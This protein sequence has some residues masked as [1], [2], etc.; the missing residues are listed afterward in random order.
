MYEPPNPEGGHFEGGG[1]EGGSLEK[2]NLEGGNFEGGNLKGRSLEGGNPLDNYDLLWILFPRAGFHKDVA[3]RAEV[4][5][6]LAAL[7]PPGFK[8]KGI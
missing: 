2:G 5:I 6:V 3:T 4:I 1:H 7:P 8:Q